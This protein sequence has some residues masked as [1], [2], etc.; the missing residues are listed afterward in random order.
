MTDQLDRTARAICAEQC[1]F[2]GEPPCHKLPGPWP[3]PE[4][5]D[6]GCHALAKAAVGSCGFLEK[7]NG[8][9]DETKGR[10]IWSDGPPPDEMKDGRLVLVGSDTG[11]QVAL[12]R[13]GKWDC[14]VWY[15]PAD[16]ITRHARLE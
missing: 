15:F 16:A 12:W 14:G 4:C 11:A 9:P 7:E 5:N 8:M 2:M 6:P 13:D 3:N 1:A 10:V